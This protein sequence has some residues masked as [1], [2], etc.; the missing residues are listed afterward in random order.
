MVHNI[1]LYNVGTEEFIH[2]LCYFIAYLQNLAVCLAP[3]ILHANSKSDKMNTS[4]SKLLQIQTSIVQLLIN[5][6]DRIGS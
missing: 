2:I 5:S 1:L 3:N 6:A 4:E